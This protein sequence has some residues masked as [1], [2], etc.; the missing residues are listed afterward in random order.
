MVAGARAEAA[1][2]TVKSFWGMLLQR[3]GDVMSDETNINDQVK[4]LTGRVAQ[5]EDTLCDLI[6]RNC[7]LKAPVV[8]ADEPQDKGESVA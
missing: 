1:R 4:I 3:R 5:I 7:L 8:M 2:Y 6:H